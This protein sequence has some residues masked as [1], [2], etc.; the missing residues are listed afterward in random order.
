M[1]WSTTRTTT[2]TPPP[3]LKDPPIQKPTSPSNEIDYPAECKGDYMPH[4]DCGMVSCSQYKLIVIILSY[5]LCL[6]GHFYDIF[7]SILLGR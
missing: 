3:P 6:R 1:T 2:T 7:S 4:S 5:M